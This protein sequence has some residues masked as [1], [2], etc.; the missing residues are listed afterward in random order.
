MD[1]TPPEKPLQPKE[2]VISKVQ[3]SI[4]KCYYQSE[5]AHSSTEQDQSRHDLRDPQEVPSFSLMKQLH[6]LLK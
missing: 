6:L 1:P 3:I 4:V 5:T 2:I